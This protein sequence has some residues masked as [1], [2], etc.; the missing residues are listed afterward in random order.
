M[1][2]LGAGVSGPTIELYVCAD[3]RYC[4]QYMVGSV[5]ERVQVLDAW[6]WVRPEDR[7]PFRD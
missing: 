7:G 6:K 2:Y 5:E 3:C 1:L 4:E